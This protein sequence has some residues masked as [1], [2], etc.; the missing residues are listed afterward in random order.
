VSL[1]VFLSLVLLLAVAGFGAGFL[2]GVRTTVPAPPGDGAGDNSGDNSG[3]VPGGGS[4]AT[5]RSASEAELKAAADA[6]NVQ[7]LRVLSE[8]ARGTSLGARADLALVR[9]QPPAAR[10]AAQ[11]SFLQRYPTSWL[12][13]VWSPPGP[14]PGAR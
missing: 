10:P 1:R 13:A 4:D 5:A 9:A 12:H 6:G 3:S 11:Q 14:G 2:A 8:R 7:R